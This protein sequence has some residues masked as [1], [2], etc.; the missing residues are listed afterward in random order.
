MQYRTAAGEKAFSYHCSGFHCAEAVSKAIIESYGDHTSKT[1][2][3][4]ATAF[5]GG[6][7]RTNQEMCGALAGGLIGIGF[8]YGRTRPESDWDIASQFAAQL[9][10]QFIIRFETTC[11]DSLLKRF[12]PQNDMMCCKQLSGEVADMLADILQATKGGANL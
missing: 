3:Q 8:L 5:G 10:T 11:C 6:V 9:R 2:Q 7:G 12:G 1:I 4:V